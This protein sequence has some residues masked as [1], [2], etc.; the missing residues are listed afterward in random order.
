VPPR[1]VTCSLQLEIVPADLFAVLPAGGAGGGVF[2]P[3]PGALAIT[4]AAEPPGG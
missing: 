2:L 4:P 3:G 1:E